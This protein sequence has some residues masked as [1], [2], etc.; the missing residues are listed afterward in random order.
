MFAAAAWKSVTPEPG[1]WW[2]AIWP[3]LL[4]A[5]TSGCSTASATV[6]GSTGQLAVTAT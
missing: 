6:S 4:R 5:R 1:S 3:M 2:P